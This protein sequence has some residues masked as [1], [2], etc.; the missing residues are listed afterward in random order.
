MLLHSGTHR[1][2][3]NDVAAFH[4]NPDPLRVGLCV[5]NQRLLDLFLEFGRR[6]AGLDCNQVRDPPDA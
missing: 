4:L 5:A 3:E 2:L 1:A 6:E